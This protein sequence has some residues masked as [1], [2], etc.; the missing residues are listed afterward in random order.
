MATLVLTQPQTLISAQTTTGTQG[1]LKL[2]GES[3]NITVVVQGNGAVD[4][5]AVT[6]EEAYWNMETDPMYAGT[7]S[8]IGS[9][10]T[11]P[12]ASQTVVHV[13]SCSSWAVRARI[14]TTVTTGTCSVFAWAT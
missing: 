1:V 5:G 10:V 4:A 3:T 14:S 13:G 11:V 7:W 12:N 6:I 8:A 9:A 2:R